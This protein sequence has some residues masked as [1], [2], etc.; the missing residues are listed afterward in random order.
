MQIKIQTFMRRSFVGRT[1][2]GAFAGHV[3]FRFIIVSGIVKFLCFV[4]FAVYFPYPF[5]L[6]FDFI[7]YVRNSL[8]NL[9][10]S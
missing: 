7:Y 9:M 3:E 10:R 1:V 5:T 2:V 8:L 4:W 6:Q